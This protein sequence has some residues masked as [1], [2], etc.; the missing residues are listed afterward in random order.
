MLSDTQY[1]GG[2]VF[3][4]GYALQHAVS[5]IW[6]QSYGGGGEDQQDDTRRMDSEHDPFRLWKSKWNSWVPWQGT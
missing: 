5:I 3:V 1:Q 6:P 4:G 2:F